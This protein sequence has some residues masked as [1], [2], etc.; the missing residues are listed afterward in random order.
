MK[1]RIF[2][3]KTY[4]LKNLECANCGGKIE[5]AI[6][7]LNDVEKAVLNFPERKLKVTGNIN[8]DTEK[9]M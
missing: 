3:Q 8:S 4:I 7:A 5:E 2:M 9:S 1:G 6:N